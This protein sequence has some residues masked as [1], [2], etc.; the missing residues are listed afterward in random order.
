MHVGS[1]LSKNSID[2]TGSRVNNVRVTYRQSRQLSNVK[3]HIILNI[4]NFT[5]QFILP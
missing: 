1:L 3:I 4:P 2:W 5:S